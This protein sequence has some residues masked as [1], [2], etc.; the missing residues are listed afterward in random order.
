MV[1]IPSRG[2]AASIR[3]AVEPASRSISINSGSDAFRRL[4][5]LAHVGQPEARAGAAAGRRLARA[6]VRRG[7]CVNQQSGNVGLDLRCR[8]FARAIRRAG[9]EADVLPVDVQ[10]RAGTRQRLTEAIRAAASTACSRSTRR[11]RAPRS[12]RCARGGLPGG[13]R[14]RR[15]TSRPRCCEAVRDGRMLFAVDQQA[16]LQGYLPVVLLTQRIRYGLFAE[17]GRGDR[18]RPDAS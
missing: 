16:Y 10:D 14:S 9:G 7:L 2:V 12:T 8:A 3:R 13:S 17:R 4:G 15:S 11:A 5:V 1:S 18:D 6:G